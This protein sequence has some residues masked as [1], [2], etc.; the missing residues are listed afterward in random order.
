MPSDVL[1]LYATYKNKEE[2]LLTELEAIQATLAD[3]TPQVLDHF[4]QAGKNILHV[5][6]ERA[7][8]LSHDIVV[9]RDEKRTDRDVCEMLYAANLGSYVAYV[10]NYNRL[11]RLANT[12]DAQG[13]DLLARYPALNGFVTLTRIPRIF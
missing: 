4:R 3:L 10:P 7:L 5:R 8:T 6:N 2:K 12:L 9:G 11:S 1:T 13:K